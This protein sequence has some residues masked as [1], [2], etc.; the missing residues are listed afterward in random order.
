ML[1]T[2]DAKSVEAFSF[3]KRTNSSMKMNSSVRKQNNRSSSML[4]TPKPFVHDMKENF[5]SSKREISSSMAHRSAAQRRP[6]DDI[7][8][9]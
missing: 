8:K 7:K 5:P 1:S 4:M 3:A 2:A 9:N 6:L